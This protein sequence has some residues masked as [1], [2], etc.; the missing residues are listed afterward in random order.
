[1]REA[2]LEFGGQESVREE[3]RRSFGLRW[4]DELRQH[5]SY[6][7]RMLRRKPLFALV[8]IATRDALDSE[9]V[10]IVN[11]ALVRRYFGGIDP[12]GC[13]F[14]YSASTREP[15][16]HIVGVV[17]DARV[18]GPRTPSVPMIWQPATQMALITGPSLQVR[19]LRDSSQI[20]ADLRQLVSDMDTRGKMVSVMP[21]REQ[22]GS[23]LWREYMV[24]GFTSTFGFVALFLACFGLYGVMSYSV[25]RRTAELGVR[26]PLGA[27]P[28]VVL[29]QTL[30][31]S[32]RLVAVGL[33]TGIPLSLA[34]E[35][36]LH[37]LLFDVAPGDP[38]VV[39]TSATLFFASATLAAY[40]PAWR[41]SRV[42][43]VVALRYE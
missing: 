17:N 8:A 13:T 37:D 29:W 21:V 35:R 16:L 11:E 23:S 20:R 1:M 5:L 4:I 26:L 9:K 12:L 32:L 19:V 25:S 42:D 34:V 10:V 22:I 6:A 43:P 38:L 41:A 24:A 33:C 7:V 36:L 30:R 15:D 3:C 14:R 31:E 27:H 2:R 18:N 28:R 40:F 39:I